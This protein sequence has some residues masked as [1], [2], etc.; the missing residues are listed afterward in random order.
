MAH[1]PGVSASSDSINVDGT[2]YL[3]PWSIQVRSISMRV[4]CHIPNIEHFHDF[5]TISEPGPQLVR[6]VRRIQLATYRVQNR[7]ELELEF[8][9]SAGL[10][11]VQLVQKWERLGQ[12]VGRYGKLQL[13]SIC[14]RPP[15]Y[16]GG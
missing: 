6:H 5:G 3:R 7:L 11:R 13:V 1:S 9:V 10:E 16:L 12:Q 14:M 8:R 2:K 4:A 15:I